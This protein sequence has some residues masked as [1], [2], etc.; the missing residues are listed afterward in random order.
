MSKMMHPLKTIT[1]WLDDCFADIDIE[2]A[3]RACN[4]LQ[5]ESSGHIKKVAA[6]VDACEFTIRRA[7]E[8]GASLLIV[9]H[10]L[11]WN[12]P[13][14]F[15][16]FRYRKL[17]L[18][19]DG[20]LAIYSMHLPL[21][22]HPEIGNN[23]LL[24]KAMGLE[25]GEAWM[26]FGGSTP[27]GRLCTVDLSRDE[28]QDRLAAAVNGP[29]HVC[30]GGPQQLAKVGI[31]TGGAGN[32]VARAAELGADTLISGEASHWAYPLAEELGVNLL[33]G[34]HYATETFG[35]KALAEKAAN[36][37][38]LEWQFIDHPTGL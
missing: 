35:V 38:D 1:D 32:D 8:A 20:D 9:H 14:P 2:D 36:H 21:D 37:F 31:V 4:G 10:G 24:A 19:L 16:G 22:A 5:V 26:E 25:P 18:L 23:V 11:F 33:L 30:P 28:L 17:K 34:G 13:H 27:V 29:V 3:T 15:T 6:A 12:E 7:I